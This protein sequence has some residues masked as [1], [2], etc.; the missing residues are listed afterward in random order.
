MSG[1]QTTPYL[2]EGKEKFDR[3]IKEHAMSFPDS[4][5]IVLSFRLNKTRKPSRVK[6]ISSSC[7]SCEKQAIQLL[8]DGP[9]WV[10]E[11][12]AKA[13]VKIQ[14]NSEK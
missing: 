2:L 8:K 13:T 5:N 12:G 11:P 7:K 4:V 9:D 1:V 6:V 14:F 10:G 3:Y